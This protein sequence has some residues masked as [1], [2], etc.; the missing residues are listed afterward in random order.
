[1]IAG[2]TRRL[3]HDP[4]EAQ[5]SQIQFVDKDI[6]HTNRVLLG[7]IVIET[8][9]KQRRLPAICTLNKAAHN[10]PHADLR[11]IS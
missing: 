5:V 3:R 1:M 7:H 9:G 4:L 6:D 11:R 8:F 10:Q 2:A